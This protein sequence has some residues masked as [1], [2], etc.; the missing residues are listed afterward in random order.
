[1]RSANFTALALFATSLFAAQAVFAQSTGAQSGA[2]QTSTP[3]SSAAQTPTAQP[4][5]G[6]IMGIVKSGNTPLP[7]ATVMAVNFDTRQRAVTTTDV[8]GNFVFTGLANGRYFIAVQMMAFAPGRGMTQIDDKNLSAR[9]DIDMTLASRLPPEERGQPGSPGTNGRRVVGVPGANPAGQPGA[10]PA[11]LPAGMEDASQMAGGAAAGGDVGSQDTAAAMQGVPGMQGAA[12]DT[13]TQSVA[14]GGNI[15]GGQMRNMSSAEIQ[16]RVSEFQQER[17]FQGGGGPQFRGGPGGGGG[18]FIMLRGGGRRG[19]DQPHGAIF[20]TL[21]DSALDASPYSLTG[22]P[23]RKPG[24]VQHQFGATLGGPL[25]IP[26]IYKGGMKNF[27]FAS[28]FGTLAQNPFDQFSTVPMVAERGGDF[29]ALGVP[30]Y[31]PSTGNPDGTGRTQFVSFPTGADAN[32]LCTNSSGCPNMIPTGRISTQAIALLNYIPNASLPGAIQNFHFV[33][34]TTSNSNNLNVRLIHNFGASSTAMPFPRRGGS[35]NTLNFGFSYRDSNNAITNPFPTLGGSTTTRSFDIPVGYAHSFGKLTNSLRFDFNRSRT[36]AQNLFAFLT[37][38]AG[39]AGI[40]GVSPSPFDWGVPNLSFTTFAGVQDANPLLDRN[41][42]FTFSD[43]MILTHGKHTLRWGGDFRRIQ[44]NTETSSDP[45]GSFTFAGSNTAQFV[46]DPTT[47]NPVQQP[48]TGFDFGDFLLGLPAQTRIQCGSNSSGACVGSANYHFRGNSWDWFLQDDW[49]LHGNFTMNLGLRY[50]YVSPLSETSNQLVNLDVAPGFTAVAPVEPGQTGPFTGAFP[51]TL[52]NPDRDNLAP[53][54][55]I[56]WKPLKNTV[57]RSS[58]GINYNTG[59]YNS[60][61]QQLAFQPPFSLTETNTESSSTSLSL[62]NGFPAPPPSSITNNYGASRN[63][64]LGYVQIWNLDVQQELSKTLL[65]NADYTGSKGTNLDILEDP[66]RTPTGLRIPGVQPFDFEAAE[67]DS[68]L[69]AGTIRLRKRLSAGVSVGGAYTYSKSIDNASSIGGGA[70]TVAQDAFNLAAERGLSNFDQ[71]HRFTGDYL[72]E[73]PLGAD[74]RWLVQ[75]GVM[76]SLFGNWEWSG[77][78]TISSG[79]PF[80]A[81]ILGNSAELARGTNGTLRANAT[82]QPV[83][84]SNPTT[85]AWFNTG[86]FTTPPSGQF[87]NVGRN[88]IRG[89]GS[90]LWDMAVTKVLPLGE[91]RMLEIRAQANNVFNRPQ[92]SSIDTTMNTAAFGQVVGTGPMRTMQ[93]V[94][95]FRF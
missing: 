61:A 65:F 5:N 10:F 26:K 18:G 11:G 15:S 70:T 19:F 85:A 89:P 52:V 74:R 76:Q 35:R 59:A 82:G 40:G 50:E 66:N 46:I 12:S 92:F 91:S 95:R 57:V 60:I 49:H 43:S 71:T 28:Y 25:N 39:Q 81:N 33:T 20:Y 21:G 1:M 30:I 41:Q 34:T 86:A 13:A 44:I 79:L 78:W 75:K 4:A 64:Q 84:L 48:G 38:V 22:Q 37:N 8:N 24:F 69:H 56:A 42:T 94:T 67:G 51:N 17:L 80:T 77:N 58:Y 14:V 87:G 27:F 16:A 45:R 3:P 63:Y 6:K 83:T 29:T 62:A 72:W 55:G 31:D 23:V 32:S 73:L 90:L 36:L 2:Q 93:I 9:V 54:V 47:G 53:R 68:I 88:T 7:G